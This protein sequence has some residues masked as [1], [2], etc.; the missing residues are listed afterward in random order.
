M[1]RKRG[2]LLIPAPKESRNVDEY[3]YAENPLI[4]Q[5]TYKFKGKILTIGAAENAIL[6]VD[7]SSYRPIQD[8]IK[9]VENYHKKRGGL[10]AK[11]N[12]INIVKSALSSLHQ[13]GWMDLKV[14][15][16]KPFGTEQIA[17]KKVSIQGE[18]MRRDYTKNS[19][20][21]LNRTQAIGA[22]RAKRERSPKTKHLPPKTS[23]RKSRK[24]KQIP[25][26]VRERKGW[27]CDECGIVLI[28]NKKMLRIRLAMLLC[29]GCYAEKDSKNV[30]QIKKTPTY[31][32]FM[33]RYRK[34]WRRRCKGLKGGNL[35]NG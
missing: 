27:K 16:R 8:W 21:R 11:D 19:S 20:S 10:V 29:M 4:K 14:S 31:K 22:Q 2:K 3:T 34:E 7:T 32:R 17:W 35:R 13:R 26:S 30:R 6:Q 9:F 5:P 25:P 24:T 23:L 15:K 28:E 1:F 18:P 12:S 33:K